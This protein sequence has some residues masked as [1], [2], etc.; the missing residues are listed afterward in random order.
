MFAWLFWFGHEAISG[1]CL[2]KKP[3]AVKS[4]INLHPQLAERGI[5]PTLDHAP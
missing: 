5:Q 1:E 4:L 3:P 2:G